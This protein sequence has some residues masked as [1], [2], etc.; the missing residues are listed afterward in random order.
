MRLLLE[1]HAIRAALTN[2]GGSVILHGV[3]RTIDAPDAYS[4]AMGSGIHCDLME[5]EAMV[6]RLPKVQRKALLDF[7][8]GLTSEQSAH[9][10][11]VK[12]SA[13][14][15]RRSVAIKAV[16]KQWAAAHPEGEPVA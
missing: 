13:L 3:E 16:A 7:V 6:N 14:R 8:D 11:S 1:R 10:T 5:A 9:Y 4:T 12:P 15:K 2:P